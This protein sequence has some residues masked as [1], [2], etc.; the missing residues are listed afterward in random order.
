MSSATPSIGLG[1]PVDDPFEIMERAFAFFVLAVGDGRD[2]EFVERPGEV[3]VTPFALAD[4]NPARP[5]RFARAVDHELADGRVEA[6]G[7]RGGLDLDEQVHA[8]VL[9][10]VVVVGQYRGALAVH[11][12][13]P[14]LLQLAVPT[15][16][17][18]RRLR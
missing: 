17:S 15:E 14:D 8:A 5:G 18:I 1:D 13:D 16:N 2:T 4:Q 9:I 10:E 11:V 3:R 7:V 6:L 12:F